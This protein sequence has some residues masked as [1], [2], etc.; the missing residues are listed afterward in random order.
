MEIRIVAVPPGEAPEAIR[1]AWV[2]LI[3]PLAPGEIGARAIPGFGVLTGPRSLLGKLW[4]LLT[5]QYILDMQYAVLVD[6]AIEVLEEAS[7]T[8]AAWWRENTPHLIR[9]G[10]FFGFAAEVCEEIAEPG[11]AADPPRE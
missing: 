5:N 11:A 8:A 4:R 7:P 2:G 1:R 9:K 6:D 3:L 10:G